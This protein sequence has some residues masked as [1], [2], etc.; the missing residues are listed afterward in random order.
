MLGL[1]QRESGHGMRLSRRALSELVFS[2]L[3]GS[4]AVEILLDFTRNV[5]SDVTKLVQFLYELPKI[6]LTQSWVELIIKPF[7]QHLANDQLY[8]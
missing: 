7:R 6:Q 8:W 2:L 4:N 3:A 5:S 1:K